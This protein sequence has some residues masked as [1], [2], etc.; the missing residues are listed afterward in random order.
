MAQ[1]WGLMICRLKHAW[2]PGQG[3]AGWQEA[4]GP[5][6]AVIKSPVAAATERRVRLL[7]QGQE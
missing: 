1:G 7:P 2:G 5:H 3:W 6:E 4:L